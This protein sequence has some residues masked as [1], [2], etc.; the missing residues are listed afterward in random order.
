MAASL[1]LCLPGIL[2]LLPRW[3]IPSSWSDFS[4]WHSIFSM[5][6]GALS[7]MLTLPVLPRYT[8]LKELLARYAALEALALVFALTAA[9]PH[10]IMQKEDGQ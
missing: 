3:L 9:S 6:K 2:S 7:G 10:K 5:A 4:Y 1:A 8:G